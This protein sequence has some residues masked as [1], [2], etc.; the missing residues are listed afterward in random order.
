MAARKPISASEVLHNTSPRKMINAHPSGNMFNFLREPSP[1]PA[2]VPVVTSLR[3][4]S[5]SRSASQ[6]RKN[7]DGNGSPSA[8][9]ADAASNN[10]GSNPSVQVDKALELAKVCSV[11]DHVTKSIGESDSDPAVLVILTSLNGA[12]L[13]LC[14]LIG[15]ED[16]K[17]ANSGKPVTNMVSLGTIPKRFRAGNQS[18]NAAA[19]LS[20]S[21]EVSTPGPVLGSVPDPDT[22]DPELQRFRDC[23]KEAEKSTLIF[24]LDMGPVPIM[25]V[26]SMSKKATLALTT[27]AAKVENKNT[28]IPSKDTVALI[29]DVLSVS[30]GMKFFGAVT[31]TY[32][33]PGDPRHGSFCTVPVR[34]DFVDKDT[35]IR[36]EKVLRSACNVSCTTPYPVILRECIRRTIDKAKTEFPDKFIKVN[37]DTG[38]FCLKVAWRDK[39]EEHPV[40]HY[41]KGAVPL[42]KEALDIRSRKIP[43]SLNIEIPV[44][45]PKKNVP[46]AIEVDPPKSP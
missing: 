9:Y 39:D 23:V 45:S 25:N 17:P 22:A 10:I 2:P 8:S 5:R 32:K 13:T 38:N 6:K 46:Q 11:C 7:S 43:D 19:V 31:K 21:R 1:A 16:A 44:F 30:S 40:W 34:Y 24:N 4:R 37:V 29:D 35:K 28:S 33:K 27:M 12:I 26:D 20:V 14:N 41:A 3:S 42:P 18:V 15:A 36:A